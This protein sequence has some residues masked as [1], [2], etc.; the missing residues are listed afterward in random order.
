M[1]PRLAATLAGAYLVGSIPVG[2]LVGRAKGID[3]RLHGSGNIGAT[4]AGRVLGKKYGILV[5]VLDVTKG[6]L[7]TSL[8]GSFGPPTQIGNEAYR[9]AFWLTAALGTVIGNIASIY[10]SFKGGK[11]VGTSLGALLGIY[12]YLTFPGILAAI[13]WLIVVTLSKYV[14]L[15]SMVATAAMPFLFIA[16][17]FAFDWGVRAHLSLLVLC[18][19]LALL[20]LLRHKDNI[21]RLLAGTENRVGSGLPISRQK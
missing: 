5:F 6:A 2:L 8:A 17:S 9:D 16:L 15:A 21:S 20:V 1:I 14:S 4:N 11:G 3:L 10:M 7:C 13:L 18:A 19:V 12:P